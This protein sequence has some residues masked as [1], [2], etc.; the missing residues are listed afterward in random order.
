MIF[1]VSIALTALTGALALLVA[2]PVDSSSIVSAQGQGTYGHLTG[3]IRVV[4]GELPEPAATTGQPQTPLPRLT[5]RVGVR[6]TAHATQ[7]PVARGLDGAELEVRAATPPGVSLT[8]QFEGLDDNDNVAVVGFSGTPPDPQLAVGPDHVVE[9][10]NVIG[11]IFNK[12]GDDIQTFSLSQFFS[13][14]PGHDD[15][16]PRIIYDALSGRWFASY[17]S[18]FDSPAG[19]DTSLLHLAASQTSDPTGAWNVYSEGFTDVFPDYPGIGVTDDK[20]TISVNLF[21]IDEEFSTGEQTIVVEKADVMAG[22]SDPATFFFAIDPNRFTVRPVHS[23]SALSDQYLATF[24]SFSFTTLT[25][26]RVTGTPAAGNVAEAEATDLTVAF[27][28]SPP[29]SVTA[30]SGSIDSGDFRLLE[31]IWRGGSLWASAS[32][33]CTPPGDTSTRSCAHLMEVDTGTNSIV[34][35]IMFG[36]ANQYYSWPAIRTDSSSNLFVSLTRTNSS[37]FAEAVVGG[38]QASDPA[39]TISGSTLLRAGEIVHQT[40]RW[41]DYLGAAVD[42]SSASCVWVVGQ[43]AKDTGGPDT[44]LGYWG[45]FI[46]ATSYAADPSSGCNPNVDTDGDGIPDE[47]DN[48]PAWPNPSQDLP[49]WPIPNDDPDCDGFTTAVESFVTTL[50]F[51]SCGTNAWPPD[52]NDDE[53]VTIADVL[54]LKAPFGSQTGDPNYDQR[55]DLNADGRITIP[56]VLALKPFF[57]LACA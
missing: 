40:G 31:A 49:A 12:S 34:Q 9:F 48:C 45:T 50:P 46:A 18:L 11:R 37:I 51:N 23:L 21:D 25:I 57:G 35:D 15:F 47:A 19:T 55:P 43:Y 7:G 30:G 52:F 16:D 42:P 14:P 29:P 39:N 44:S 20:F 1:H 53:R 3:Y 36:E 17:V 28:D 26:I 38:R 5:P 13:V 54:A 27:Q 56:D 8:R 33:V 32:A 6:S 41:G 2:I 22:V 10:V 24:D 4:V